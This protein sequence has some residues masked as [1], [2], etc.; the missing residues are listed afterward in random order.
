MDPT[1]AQ[2]TDPRWLEFCAA[3]TPWALAHGART[4]LTQARAWPRPEP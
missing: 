2:P 4:S 3:L 1:C